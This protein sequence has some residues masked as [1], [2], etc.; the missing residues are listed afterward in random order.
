MDVVV[1]GGVGWIKFF[2]VGA[3]GELKHLGV[4]TSLPQIPL[5]AELTQTHPKE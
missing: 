4:I 5:H 1:V 2:A 3:A